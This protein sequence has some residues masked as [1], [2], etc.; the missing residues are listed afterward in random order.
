ML[1]KLKTDVCRANLELVAQ[2][3]VVLTWGN[4]SGIDRRRGLVV[5]K[6]SGVSYDGMTPGDMVVVSLDT[7]QV[8]DGALKPSSDTPTHLVLYRA[9]EGVGGIV[10]T[11]SPWATAWAQARRDIPPLGTTHADF[12]HG[13]VP[14]TRPLTPAEIRTDYEANT[15]RV[16]ARR[17]AR[18]DPLA[19][20][21]VLV[22][23]HGP[24]AWGRAVKDAVHH[25]VILEQVARMATETLRVRPGAK[26]VPQGLLDKHYYRKHGPGAYYGQQ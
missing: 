25:A 13:L 22:A 16:I 1:E 3:L 19:C 11:H 20:P 4:V 2:G 24:F 23:S 12:C 6:P 5:I 7:G 15:G 9:F 18:L 8:V 17:F 21:A 14:C 26:P 10:H